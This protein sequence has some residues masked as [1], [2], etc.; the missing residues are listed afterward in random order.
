MK[1]FVYISILLFIFGNSVFAQSREDNHPELDWYTIETEHFKVHFHNGAER[2]ARVV[3]KVAEDVYGPVTD[4]YQWHPDDKIHFIIKDHDDNSNG[5]AFYYDNKVEIWAPQMT[6]ILRG[7][8]NW[9]RNVV[10]HEFTHMISLG[11]ARKITRRIPAF[12]FQAIGYEQ[13]KRPDVL[14]GYPNVI[15]SYPIAM[16]VMPMWLAEGMAQYQVS[17]LDYDRWDSHR[18]MLI[19][20]AVL[21]NQ[22]HSF[23]EMGV[24]GKNSLGNERTYNAGYALTLYIA[25]KYGEESLRKIAE[26]M[27]G[28]FRVSVNGAL[29]KVLGLN[30]DEL[31]GQWQK[32]LINYYSKVL[33]EIE[34]NRVEGET[35][36]KK[37]LANIFPV[38][39]PKGDKFAYAGSKSAD[40][41]SQTSLY[42][43]N[44]S[45]GKAKKLKGGVD[46]PVSWAPD[47]EKIIY[48]RKRRNKH[49]SHYY[50][51]HVYDLAKKKEKRL[52][53]RLRVHSPTWSPDGQN[54]ICI[55]QSDGTDNFLRLDPAGKVIEHLTKFKNG[56]ALFTPRF[57]PDGKLIAFSKSRR[58]GRDLLL[59]DLTSHQIKTLIKSQ[60]DARE[61][62]F[63]SDGQSVYFS[64]DRTGIFNI[65]SC[66]LNGENVQQWT[67][68][69]GGAFMPTVSS[70][71]ELVFSNFQT[72][73]YKISHITDPQPIDANVE[74]VAE[75]NGGERLGLG[76]G[77]KENSDK[78]VHARNYNDNNLP[79]FNTSPYAR[80]YGSLMFL[81]RAMID[82]GTLKLGSYFYA[83]DVLDRYSMIGGIS[84]NR[85]FD[86][87]AFG[88]FEYKKWA[89]TLFVELYGFTRNID[90]K[91]EVFEDY[92][93]KANVTIH[94]NLLEADIGG[95]YRLS[96]NMLL[97]TQYAHSRYT[98]KIRDF[99]FQGNKW[100]S[101]SNTYFIGN[102][103]SIDWNFDQIVA[104]LD[105]RINPSVGRKINVKYS[106]EFN[107]FFSDFSTD[108][109]YNTLQEVY[110]NYNYNRLEVNWN[111]HIPLPIGRR[112]A[113]T[114]RFRGGYIDKPIDDFFNFFAGGLPGLKGYPY[115]SIEGRK[116]LSAAV[117]YRFPI[118]FQKQFRVANLTFDKLYGGL[119]FEFADAFDWDRFSPIKPKKDVGV[120]LRLSLFSFYGFPTALYF[121]AAYGLDKISVYH[122]YGI[123]DIQRF[124]YGNEWRY[125]FGVLFD[126]I[127]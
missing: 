77:F 90:E 105:S 50:D 21:G 57:S 111:E 40:Y 100:V 117:I 99:I 1:K 85:S 45:S 124:N 4:L 122:E 118:L 71:G 93:E 59:M 80:E 75:R 123:G 24:F 104:R 42:I 11:A 91:I 64:W 96:D 84:L 116:L 78:V 76:N 16:T 27:R 88:I 86:M 120:S 98:S 14:Y 23:D 35:I 3:A 66:D 15:V 73:G 51:L 68:V 30:G 48:G 107:K 79:K 32:E 28:P 112:H 13:E 49:G 115:Y 126:F 10:T 29:K 19:R 43:Y 9:L 54:I 34:K 65:Y 33:T 114:L 6:F 61:P 63:G 97:R 113:L 110:T 60:G 87:D 95:Y 31:Y 92:P 20:T 38:W 47:G 83:S 106:R 8:H 125:H 55:V 62:C 2:S 94:F 127:D 46:T 103:F 18:D 81:P 37:G 17:G 89:P 109:P 25:K 53:N 52:T 101:P 108:N 72:D 70:S 121:D 36:L 82:Y 26:A 119:F 12:Y 39:S 102:E 69:T 5:A 58:H 41:L 44:L 7:T 22:M 67:N 56:E 74:L